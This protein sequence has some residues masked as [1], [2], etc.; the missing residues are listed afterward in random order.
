MSEVVIAKAL[1]KTASPLYH[2]FGAWAVSLIILIAVALILLFILTRARKEHRQD[3][4]DWFK[5]VRKDREEYERS[6]KQRDDIIAKRE[7]RQLQVIENNTEALGK[8][9]I[10]M[11]VCNNRKPA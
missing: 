2:I 9:E 5:E 1:E 8:V 3:R 10:A 4:N 7:E 6:L 11:L